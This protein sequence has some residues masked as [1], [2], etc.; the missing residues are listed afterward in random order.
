MIFGHRKGHGG[1][2]RDW[3]RGLS[4]GGRGMILG[5]GGG[6][7]ADRLGFQE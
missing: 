7:A 3:G 4:D 6:M 2:R 5:H 1:V